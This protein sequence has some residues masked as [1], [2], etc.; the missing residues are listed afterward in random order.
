MRLGRISYANMAPVFYGLEADVEEV[1]GVP[2]ELTGCC[3]TASSTSPRS[4]RS[5]TP[6]TPTT[7]VS[8]RGCASRPRARSTRSSSSPGCRSVTSLG[9][10]HARERHLGRADEGLLPEG[11]DR[12]GRDGAD[13]K[14]LIGDAA[15]QSAFEDPTP[16]FDLGRLWLERTGLP[17]VF[18]VWAAPE[19]VAE[20]LADLEHAL[21]ASVRLAAPSPSGSPARR[22]SATAIRPASSPATSRS[23]ATA[24]GRARRGLHLPRDGALRRRARRRA[25]LASAREGERDRHR[26]ARPPSPTFSRGARRRA[27]LRRGRHRAARARA[28]SSRSAVSR[29]R[30]AAET[31]PLKVTFIV[32]R[33]LNYTNVCVTDCDFC[34]F[35]V[36]PAT[37]RGIPAAQAGH[38]QEDRGDACD[39]R[40]RPAHAGRPPSRSRNRLRRGPSARSRPAT[41]SI[42]TRCR[43]LRSST[44]RAAR[45]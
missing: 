38:L 42:S 19:P 40:H 6:A 3:S 43:H 11:R 25:R 36:F 31:I 32:D 34:A 24:S 30:S 14:L 7:C 5:S 8:C 16:H 15:L 1:S 35:S 41:R 37:S 45:S 10:R 17:M 29:T 22:A 21:V 9:R 23:S 27:D 20:G 44:S 12:A 2:T 28:T 18:A 39:R 33:N 26:R 13:A 4:P